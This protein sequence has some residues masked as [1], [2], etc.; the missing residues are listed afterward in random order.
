MDAFVCFL[1]LLFVEFAFSH[2]REN[3]VKALQKDNGPWY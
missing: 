1:R 2:E 3:Q